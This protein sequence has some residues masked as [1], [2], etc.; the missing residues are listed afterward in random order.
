[1]QPRH[2]ILPNHGTLFVSTDFHG[3]GADFRRMRQLFESHLA[4]TPQ[5]HWAILG[6]LVHAP[7]PQ[8]RRDNPRLYDFDDESWEIVRGVSE[9]HRQYPERLHLILGNHDHGHV[10]GPHPRKFYWDEADH[11]ERSL[12]E[13]QLTVLCNLFNQALIIIFAPCGIMCTHGVPSDFLCDPR[14]VDAISF[15][16]RKNSVT[17]N[18]LLATILRSYSQPGTNTA[19]MLKQV[20][21]AIGLELSVAVHGH[22]RDEAGWYAEHGNQLQPVMFGAP[23]EEKRYLK[24]DLSEKY[25]GTDAIRD[26]S[27]I[28]R[29][30]APIS[31]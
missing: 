9:L 22:D 30:H 2:R 16:V 24:L 27:E 26:G 8:S 7:D 29:V 5:T 12:S 21:Q 23:D 15:D 11:L 18:A 3:N 14:D 25:S 31:E 4:Q 6:D 1:M 13:Q 28:L 19:R 20:G 17:Q 10:G